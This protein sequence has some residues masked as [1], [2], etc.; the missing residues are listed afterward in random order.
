MND[1]SNQ[2]FVEQDIRMITASLYIGKELG[3]LI[4][5]EP[6]TGDFSTAASDTVSA[7]V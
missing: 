7:L 1:L 4:K 5:N 2:G 6:N 3:F